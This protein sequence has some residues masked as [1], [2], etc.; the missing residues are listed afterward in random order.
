MRY[1]LLWAVALTVL[2]TLLIKAAY[3]LV[4]LNLERTKAMGTEVTIEGSRACAN[5]ICAEICERPTRQVE[6]SPGSSKGLARQG[7]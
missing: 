1:L 3:P 6:S 5:G 2:G 4:C 7:R